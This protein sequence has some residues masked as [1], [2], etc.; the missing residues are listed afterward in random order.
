MNLQLQS[1]NRNKGGMMSRKSQQLANQEMVINNT[2]R[3]SL[4]QLQ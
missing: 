1:Q 4:K 3:K 2:S